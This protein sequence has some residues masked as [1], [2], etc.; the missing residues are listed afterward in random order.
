MA[1]R[2]QLQRELENLGIK[3]VWFQPPENT[4]LK[5]PAVIYKLSRLDI[6][7]ADNNPFSVKKRYNLIY[8]TKNPD[9]PMLEKLAWAFP[10]ISYNTS[11]VSDKLYHHSFELYF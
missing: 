7:H 9:D 2:L 5:Y 11:Y 3:N 6:R 10:T 1:S 8:I 4:K